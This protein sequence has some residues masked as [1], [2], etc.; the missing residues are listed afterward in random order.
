MTRTDIINHLIE[1]KGYKKYLE[2]G[3]Q[4]PESNFLKVNA[5]YKVGVE[6]Y[7]VGDW[8]EKGI[9]AK[10]SDNFFELIQSDETFDI[11][12][13]DGLHTREQCLIDIHNSLNHLSEGGCILVHDCL[14]TEEYQTTIEDNGREWT[15]DVYKSI[16]DIKREDGLQVWTIDTDWGVGF[17]RKNPNCMGETT[18]REINFELYTQFRNQLLN[19]KSVE[20]WK[21]LV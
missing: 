10:T 12:F 20:E 13:I 11:V 18:D 16:V 19:V 5:E 6:P 4:Y 3:V 9:I 15:G 21:S 7:P 8:Q 17:I 2:I 14:P 1:V